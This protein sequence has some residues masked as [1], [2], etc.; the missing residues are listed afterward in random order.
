MGSKGEKTE[1]GT[2]ASQSSKSSKAPKDEP[3]KQDWEQ[4]AGNCI[5][6]TLHGNFSDADLARQTLEQAVAKEKM[7]VIDSS[8]RTLADESVLHTM[9]LR[10][11]HAA[12]HIY[13]SSEAVFELY[14]C[15]GVNDGFGVLNAFT[16]SGRH[17]AIIVDNQQFTILV[18]KPT[19]SH[20]EP[21]GNPASFVGIPLDQF[22][23]DPK[24]DHETEGQKTYT[25]RW[26]SEYHAYL[27]QWSQGSEITDSERGDETH[28]F[29]AGIVTKLPRKL[30]K[31]PREIG[32]LFYVDAQS[33]ACPDSEFVSEPKSLEGIP[34]FWEY[35]PPDK[36]RYSAL[37]YRNG[38]FFAL[39]AFPHFS[40]LFVSSNTPGKEEVSKE[41][42]SYFLSRFE[43]PEQKHNGTVKNNVQTR[44]HSLCLF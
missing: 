34:D 24:G 9:L 8:S 21:F 31:E 43:N 38:C 28:Y 20:P 15:T 3:R 17:G 12:L 6:A 42:I 1:K 40:S 36:K 7:R 41:M 23:A 5:L 14:T 19:N 18:K 29:A 35:C 11:S 27:R 25:K 37:M 44:Q 16:N 30:C 32:K 39:H 26:E 22:L 33:A 13:N 4:P 2:K 10:E